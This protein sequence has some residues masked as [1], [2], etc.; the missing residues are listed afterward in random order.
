MRYL[1]KISEQIKCTEG[2]S[3]AEVLK[4]KID[5]KKV[6]LKRIDK[7]YAQTTYSVIREAEVMQW[8]KGKL[9]VPDV[10]EHGY[11]KNLEYMIMSEISG[12]HIDDF[13]EEPLQY[14]LN[15]VKA[16]KLLHSVDI[17]NCPFISNLD[18]RLNELRYLLDNNLADTN[19]S[20]WENT[21]IFT[22]PEELYEWLLNNK[23]HEDFVF[24]H[25]DIGANLFIQNNELFFYD[26]ARCGIADKW[27][28]IAFC[29]RDIR[30]YFPGSNY[31]KMFFDMLGI[32]PDY[33]K[34]EYF[35]LLDELF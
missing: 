21:T 18:T 24:S 20:N 8:L 25:G 5:E 1:K 14:I 12:K 2:M 19:V 27:L 15:L 11:D 28:D 17:S 32:E 30:D 6:Y 3:P 31:E 26:L 9:N 10:L 35:I 22:E 23:P 4:C 7:I 34:I 29:V 16:I 13:A 33:K